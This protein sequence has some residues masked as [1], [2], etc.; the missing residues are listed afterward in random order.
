MTAL[1]RWSGPPIICEAGRYSYHDLGYAGLHHWSPAPTCVTVGHRY[2][3][4][5]EDRI[6]ELPLPK[7]ESSAVHFAPR[8][9]PWMSRPRRRRFRIQCTVSP[10]SVAR[11]RIR[12][13]RGV[14]PPAEA[15][16][17]WQE[18]YVE[19]VP[20]TDPRSGTGQWE[21]FFDEK[22]QDETRLDKE[23]IDKERR[24]VV[25]VASRRRVYTAEEIYILYI[26]DRGQFSEMKR[27]ALALPGDELLS[28]DERHRYDMWPALTE[29][30]GANPSGYDLKVRQLTLQE[31][32]RGFAA[33]TTLANQISRTKNREVSEIVAAKTASARAYQ[34][35]ELVLRLYLFGDRDDRRIPYLREARFVYQTIRLQLLA[36]DYE[37]RIEQ[38]S[39]GRR[40]RG[41]SRL[42]VVPFMLAPGR[43]STDAW[44]KF[45]RDASDLRKLLNEELDLIEAKYSGFCKEL[46]PPRNE[47]SPCYTVSKDRK[48]A[49]SEDRAAEIDRYLAE[50]NSLKSYLIDWKAA[51]V[52]DAYLAIAKYLKRGKFMCHGGT[53]YGTA[54]GLYDTRSNKQVLK[55]A[56]DIDR[57]EWLSG[58]KPWRPRPSTEYGID[59]GLRHGLAADTIAG[60]DDDDTPIRDTR[61]PASAALMREASPFL[62]DIRTISPYDEE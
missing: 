61:E 57:E 8:V 26:G 53:A 21:M 37:K 60:T 11:A 5:D 29:P 16:P 36:R 9:L 33:M 2:S 28:R 34:A 40:K 56:G 13:D 27:E 24:D 43:S 44:L 47:D 19:P 51:W 42:C 3:C 50:A 17:V 18:P 46:I 55:D 39:R 25:S 58:P 23:Q 41:P 10:A 4:D 30:V 62:S 49:K 14:R 45:N 6:D 12:A 31:V 1:A 52:R 7:W 54:P 48:S 38:V 35:A 59:V 22:L 20:F 15:E 32:E